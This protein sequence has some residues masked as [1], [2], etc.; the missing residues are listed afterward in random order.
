MSLYHGFPS[1][2]ASCSLHFNFSLYLP[3]LS[4]QM[5]SSPYLVTSSGDKSLF[6]L[7]FSY[8]NY[9]IAVQ[10]TFENERVGVSWSDDERLIMSRHHQGH[11]EQDSIDPHNH[12]VL[13]GRGGRNN[14]H[15][16]NEILRQF[17]RAQKDKYQVA[18]KKGKS[19]LSRLIVRQMHELDPPARFVVSISLVDDAIALNCEF[20]ELIRLSPYPFAPL[21]DVPDF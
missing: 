6:G 2:F 10:P 16:G 9:P 18:S 4:K 15:S 12:D 8:H 14:Q 1:L 5:H 11:H 19:A 17:A 21:C 13:L 20:F 3:P 7:E